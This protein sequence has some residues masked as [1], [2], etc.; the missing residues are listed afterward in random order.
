MSFV[1]SGLCAQLLK[2]IFRAPRPSLAL[3]EAAYPY[4]LKGISRGGFTS[5]P[6]GHTTTIFALC[7]ILALQTKNRNLQ[8]ALFMVALMVAYSRIYLG[9]HFPVDILAGALLGYG[10]ALLIIN[11]KFIVK[12]VK[13]IAINPDR[14]PSES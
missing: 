8:V 4:F 11:L 3:S 2:A 13:Q 9:S 7:T 12:R 14:F 6:S 5:F 1:L 10:S